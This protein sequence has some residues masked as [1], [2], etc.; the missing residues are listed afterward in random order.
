[1]PLI[2]SSTDLR[3]KYNEISTFCHENREPVFITKNGQGDLVVM[4]METFETLNGKLE[5]YRLLDEGR[6]AAK[7]G[8]KRSY[9]DVFSDI[10]REIA[11]GKL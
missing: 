10:E 5:L 7:T 1:M 2:Q 6:A 8:R 11:D 3:N 9:E 4:S